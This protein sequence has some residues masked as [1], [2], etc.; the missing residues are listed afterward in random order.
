[1]K[2]GRTIRSAI[3]HSTIKL[4]DWL[5]GHSSQEGHKRH[6][7]HPD[8]EKKAWEAA[9][10]RDSNPETLKVLSN[11]IQD[12]GMSEAEQGQLLAHAWKD[13]PRPIA[14][15]YLPISL[16]FQNALSPYINH[17]G[18]TLEEMDDDGTYTNLMKSAVIRD[19]QEG[20][21]PAL[22]HG[23][24]LPFPMEEGK[25][26][27]WVMEGTEYHRTEPTEKTEAAIHSLSIE[28]TPGVL[29]EPE[30]FPS[31]TVRE[32]QVQDVDT[33]LLAFT[34]RHLHFAGLEEKFRLRY[35][36]ISPGHRPDEDRKS[37]RFYRVDSPDNPQRFVTSDGMFAHAL[38]G[39]L[40]R[41]AR[42]TKRES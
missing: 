2:I 40:E 27:I 23:D 37:F 20:I 32:Q 35:D 19:T 3:E 18:L 13:A 26:L 4:S 30:S 16:A 42:E 34:D 14:T 22:Q 9:I 39:H 17:T 12:A 33:G 24:N 10:N 1:M 11:N 41:R 28:M 7:K 36:E 6:G 21:I 38:A 15:G 31:R 5:L 29:L 25:K 8:L